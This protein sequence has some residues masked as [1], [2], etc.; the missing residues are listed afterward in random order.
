MIDGRNFFNQPVKNNLMSCNNIRK[1]VGGQADDY[2][3]VVYYI[4][5]ISINTIKW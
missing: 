2:T 3:T 5:I 1:I 4:I